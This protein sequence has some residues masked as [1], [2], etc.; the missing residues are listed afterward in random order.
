MSESQTSDLPQTEII[1]RRSGRS[2]RGSSKLDPR[3]VPLCFRLGEIGTQ[4]LYAG[5]FGAPGIHP[6]VDY[7][8]RIYQC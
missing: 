3:G 7:A 4:H 2:T 1:V 8:E 6:A 5:R